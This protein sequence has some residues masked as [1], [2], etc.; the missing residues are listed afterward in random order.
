MPAP[1]LSLVRGSLGGH[2]CNA[3]GPTCGAVTSAL[4]APRS[5]VAWMTLSISAIYSWQE[6]KV[7]PQTDM[8][9]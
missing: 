6:N 4:G 9:L 3:Q 1:G 2:G 8:F 5:R 7:R